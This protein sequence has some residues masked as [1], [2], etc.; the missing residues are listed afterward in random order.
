MRLGSLGTSRRDAEV[1]RERLIASGRTTVMS[2][3]LYRGRRVEASEAW[4]GLQWHGHLRPTPTGTLDLG[5]THSTCNWAAAA[6][7][8]W[9]SHCD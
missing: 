9:E 7:A 5:Q 8:D 4:D 1:R 2:S 6:Q 3:E